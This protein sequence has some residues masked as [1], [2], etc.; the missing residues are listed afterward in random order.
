MAPVASGQYWQHGMMGI[1]TLWATEGSWSGELVLF[2]LILM[3]AN[4]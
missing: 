1:R 2:N 3:R 4:S